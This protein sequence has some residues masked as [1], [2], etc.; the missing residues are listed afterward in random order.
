MLIKNRNVEFNKL[1][2]FVKNNLYHLLA[3]IL[4]DLE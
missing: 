2:I 3:T 4:R 1:L